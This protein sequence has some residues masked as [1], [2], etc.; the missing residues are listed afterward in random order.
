VLGMACWA[1]CRAEL[2]ASQVAFGQKSVTVLMRE[3]TT[4]TLHPNPYALSPNYA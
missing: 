3:F 4:Q 2:S 1:R